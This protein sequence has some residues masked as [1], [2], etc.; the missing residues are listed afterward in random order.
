MLKMLATKLL[1]YYGQDG[2]CKN[3]FLLGSSVSFSP[4]CESE[5]KIFGLKYYFISSTTFKI[6]LL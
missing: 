4:R 1:S 3:D 6:L 5:I 2:S